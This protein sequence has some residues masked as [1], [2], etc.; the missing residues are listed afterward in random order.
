MFRARLKKWKPIAAIHIY[1]EDPSRDDIKYI[2]VRT[3]LATT[4]IYTYTRT[5]DD[6]HIYIYAWPKDVGQ[7]HNKNAYLGS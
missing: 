2:H 3:R 7:I 5:R 1:I 6:I 4:L